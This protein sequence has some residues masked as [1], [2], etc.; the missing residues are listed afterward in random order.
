MGD[1]KAEVESMIANLEAKTGKPLE[2]WVKL[3]KASGEAKHGGIVAHL[4]TKHGLGHGYANLVAHTVLKSASVFAED[5]DDL[6][7]AQYAGPKAALLPWYES[8]KKTIGAFGSDIEFAPKKANVSV[9]RSKQF[10]LIQPSTATRMDI[11]LV[12]KGVAPKGRLE[13]SGSWSAM[14]THRVR[15]ESAAGIDK[16]LI[17]WLKQAYGAA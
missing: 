8:L 6:V 4:K 15:V 14:M 3:A 2:A 5:T 9:R 16:E 7:A 12:L 10:A 13:A 17:G 1:P 11:G